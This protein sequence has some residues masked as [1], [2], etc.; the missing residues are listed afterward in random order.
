MTD[1]PLAYKRCAV[2]ARKST[3]FG[4][5]QAFTSIDAQIDSCIKH[6]VAHA[7]QGWVH[8]DTYSD[9]AVSGGTMDRPEMQRLLQDARDGKIDVVVSYKLDRLSRS[10]RDFSNLTHE[11]DELGVSLVLVTQNVDTSTPVGRMLINLLS[12]FAEFERDMT[13]ERISH[14]AAALAQQ[15][16]WNAGRPPYGYVL[17]DRRFLHIDPTEGEAVRSMFAKVAAG[18]HPGEVAKWLNDTGAAMQRTRGAQT[19]PKAWNSE[20]VRRIIRNRLYIGVI[21]S[22]GEEYPGKHEALVTETLW[23][24]ANKVMAAQ[25]TKQLRTDLHDSLVYPLRGILCCPDCGRVLY[26]VYNNRRGTIRRYYVCGTHKKKPGECAFT[27]FSAETVEKAVALHLATLARDKD[28]LAVLQQKL[29]H[30]ERGDISEALANIEGLVGR[31]SDSALDTIFHALYESI[32]YD[33][34]A[35]SLKLNRY[36]ACPSPRIQ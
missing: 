6:I 24:K 20:A 14:K 26:S 5:Q 29:P 32:T 33:A 13:R 21:T 11:F 28:V 9:V 4:M 34:D 22:K 10:L 16:M 15:G 23:N 2:Y 17:D 7:A 25:G 31:M 3:D 30:I 35:Q 1:S 18:E 19:E 12:S 27:G 8:A 36:T